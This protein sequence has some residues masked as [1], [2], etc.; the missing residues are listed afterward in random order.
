VTVTATAT[1]RAVSAVVYLVAAVV[2]LFAEVGLY[3]YMTSAGHGSDFTGLGLLLTPI[4]LGLF[5]KA[6]VD[7][8]AQPQNVVLAQI[9]HQTNGVLAAKIHE[10]ATAAVRSVLAERDAA[11]AAAAASAPSTS[12][13]IAAAQSDYYAPGTA[14][15]LPAEDFTPEP[16][17]DYDDVPAQPFTD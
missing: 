17:P 3:V 9:Q 5:V 8:A 13:A 11:V 14:P 15:A 10:G 7:S 12:D 2:V 4:V 6:G 1:A 16:A